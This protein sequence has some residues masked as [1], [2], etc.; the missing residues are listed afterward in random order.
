MASP[1]TDSQPNFGGLLHPGDCIHNDQLTIND[2]IFYPVDYSTESNP[3]IQ[4]AIDDHQGSNRF[5]ISLSLR[6]A[7]F[8]LAH[9]TGDFDTYEAI[10]R[11]IVSTVCNEYKGRFLEVV[12]AQDGTYMELDQECESVKRVMI[13]LHNL[14]QIPFCPPAASV[15]V[16]GDDEVDEEAGSVKLAFHNMFESSGTPSSD[17][18][19]PNSDFQ[20]RAPQLEIGSSFESLPTFYDSF[21]PRAD[22]LETQSILSSKSGTASNFSISYSSG[23]LESHSSGKRDSICHSSVKSVNTFDVEKPSSLT[24]FS[25]TESNGSRPAPAKKDSKEAPLQPHLQR[26]VGK[27][28]SSKEEG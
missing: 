19:T 22:Y 15:N 12:S 11:D 9:E 14:S 27:R 20:L 13:S 4:L 7:E 18:R 1:P 3:T 16:C 23:K 8:I 10:A 21:Q 25:S 17:D 5:Q 28:G 2:V 26:K 6:R 24:N